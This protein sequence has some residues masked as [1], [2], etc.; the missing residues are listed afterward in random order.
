MQEFLLPAMFA[1]GHHTSKALEVLTA[2]TA[3]E[4]EHLVLG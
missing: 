4:L 1:L 3:A 2:V